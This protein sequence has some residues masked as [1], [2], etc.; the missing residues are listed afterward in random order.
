M[1]WGRRGVVAG[2]RRQQVPGTA[3]KGAPPPPPAGPLRPG[4]RTLPPPPAPGLRRGEAEEE[5]EEDRGQ[6]RGPEQL[7]RAEPVRKVRGDSWPISP[8]A[9]AR[10]QGAL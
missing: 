5:E 2:H 10:R 7:H 6:R 4:T 8:L 1:S 9:G 3:P